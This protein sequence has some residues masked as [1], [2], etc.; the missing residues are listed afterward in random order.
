[1]WES[2]CWFCLDFN[3]FPCV[4]VVP[5]SLMSDIT[6]TLSFHTRKCCVGMLDLKICICAVP[7]G[8]ICILN[9]CAFVYTYGKIHIGCTFIY[10][11]LIAS[12]AS[13]ILE[14]LNTKHLPIYSSFANHP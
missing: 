8:G 5:T 7:Q 12:L 9:V 2:A 6:S 10:V 4:C 1:M 14:I 11:Y 13:T 3:F